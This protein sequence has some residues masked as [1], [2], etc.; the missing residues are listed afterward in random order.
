[1]LLETLALFMWILSDLLRSWFYIEIY[2]V[3]FLFSKETAGELAVIDS[4]DLTGDLD[5]KAL[6][7]S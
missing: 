5:V 4:L 2:L 7:P 1:M 6:S 3:F